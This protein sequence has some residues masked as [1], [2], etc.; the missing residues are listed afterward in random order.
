MRGQLG[1][2]DC[3]S[4]KERFYHWFTTRRT[5]KGLRKDGPYPAFT[6]EMADGAV[7]ACVTKL[8]G[9]AAIQ[10]NR[11]ARKPPK[12]RTTYSVRVTGARALTSFEILMPFLMGEKQEQATL[13]LEEFSWMFENENI[14]RLPKPLKGFYKYL[15]QKRLN[16]NRINPLLV[17]R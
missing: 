4:E 17:P 10:V 11:Q 9:T 3:C 16:A 7:M 12:Y 8:V 13:M 2:Q 6:I 14:A 5:R 1:S 15:N